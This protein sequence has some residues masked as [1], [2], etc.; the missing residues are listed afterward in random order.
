M[1]EPNKVVSDQYRASVVATTDGQLYTGRIVNEND[2]AL[3]ILVDPEDSTK[4]VE[5]PKN[6]VEEM[7]PSPESLMPKDLLD[8]AQRE[9][10]ARPDRLPP[11][12]RR[13]E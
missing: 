12:A 11:L 7:K 10:G 5:V 13:L 1:I 8:A 4:V 2:K 9:R 6:E 3:T